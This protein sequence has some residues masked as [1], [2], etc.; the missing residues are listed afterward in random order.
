MKNKM[1]KL[2][3]FADEETGSNESTEN[4]ENTKEEKKV[5]QKDI[6]QAEL[7]PKYTDE[8]VDKLID[9]K[10][11]QWQKKQEKVVI[12]AK[13]LAEMTVTEKAEY[14]REQL[15]KELDEYKKKDALSQMEKQAR[16]ILAAEGISISSELLST[17]VTTDA[18]Q[19][20]DAIDDFV[21]AF[22]A[23]V[24]KEVR[25]K[26]KGS[27]PR[28]GTVSGTPTMT[29]KEIMAIKDSELRQKKMLE[30]KELFD[31]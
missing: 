30:N 25:E 1:L 8:D 27:S 7:K 16:K 15:Q 4:A 14:E 23:A 31:F 13:K 12:E 3:L 24:E 26:L 5:S 10:F 29:K 20:K 22:K 19:T 18:K 11:S 17:M 6:K 21:K 9:K 28:K 2:Q